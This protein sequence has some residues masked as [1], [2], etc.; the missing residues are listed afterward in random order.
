MRERAFPPEKATALSNSS[1]NRHMRI[2]CAQQNVSK[3]NN[4][5]QTWVSQRSTLDNKRIADITCCRQSGRLRVSA[6]SAVVYWTRSWAGA[7][8]LQA[9][10]EAA[11]ECPK[12]RRLLDEVVGR[13]TSV[14]AKEGMRIFEDIIAQRDARN[15]QF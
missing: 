4:S 7:Q 5:A 15:L 14:V 11:R 8:A 10:W 13:C 6:Q 1:S 3:R 2:Y 12:C 9:E